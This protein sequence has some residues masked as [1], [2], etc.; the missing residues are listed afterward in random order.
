[1]TVT[2]EIVPHARLALAPEN[3]R[4]RDPLKVAAVAA[5][6]EVI[7]L[8][9]PLSGY[10]DGETV[11]VDAG[12]YRLEAF[13][14]LASQKRMPKAYKAG[15][16]VTVQASADQAR[17]RSIAENDVREAPHP[18]DRILAYKALFEDG[19][20][21]PEKIAAACAVSLVDVKKLLR[22]KDVAAEILAA[23]RAGDV[24]LDLVQAFSI[25]P[26]PA[27]QLEAFAAYNRAQPWQRSAHSV[28]NLLKQGTLPARSGL[29]RF[30]GREAYE[31]AGGRFAVDLFTYDDPQVDWLDADLANR[32]A[33]KK[34]G[35]LA[36]EVKAEGWAEVI[37]N[38]ESR[39]FWREFERMGAEPYE[40]SEDEEAADAEAA[41]TLED[42][43][44]SDDDR[45]KAEAVI[46]A[47]DAKADRYTP[48]Q[49]AEGV[50]FVMIGR[51][52]PE[53]ERG[54]KRLEPVQEPEPGAEGEPTGEGGDGDGEGE[55]A[56]APEPE[57]EPV[58]VYDPVEVWN[59]GG[60][61][62]LTKIGTASVRAALVARPADAYD[63]LVAHLAAAT[64]HGYGRSDGAA[65]LT[66]RPSY[67]V[68][69]K[70]GRM[71]D[72]ED[73]LWAS[74]QSWR[75]RIPE[76]FAE[77]LPVVVALKPKEKAALLALT[78]GL[79]LDAS[80]PGFYPYSR[81]AGAWAQ[82]ATIC[83]HIGHNVG[84]HWTPDAALLETVP[85]G[86]LLQGLAACGHEAFDGSEKRAELAAAL[87][88]EGKAKGWLPKVLA[89]LNPPAAP[90]PATDAP[91]ASG[92][93][94]EPETTPEPQTV[95]LAA[96]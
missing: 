7:G 95:L 57:A 15:V 39:D 62:T 8:V 9:H 31:K 48:A 60:H 36:K 83:Q 41:A 61:A 40:Y 12:G 76:A 63:V 70:D 59:H 19:R 11:L 51:D 68:T 65:A 81:K 17:A 71:A 29:A 64:L 66:L 32:L 87:E 52:G 30:V 5:S 22:L 46:A 89:D 33:E 28:R 77:A 67:A 18:A 93:A 73:A 85:K 6:I 53:V 58:K 75:E 38:P 24:T 79:T 72:V 86:F 91:E 96:E 27:V 80:E 3:T 34:L 56:P 49:M 42:P 55:G 2:Y 82:L 14:L 35:K 25:H 43:E 90:E 50:A 69:L 88:R 26:D 20:M 16:P 44:A 37:V 13:Q 54:W 94:A 74:V 78:V 45:D 92:E 21:A 23:C 47:L 10:R 4:T 84:D 1:M